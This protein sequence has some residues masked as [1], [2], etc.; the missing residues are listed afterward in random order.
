[1]KVNV[2]SFGAKMVVKCPIR[3]LT[4][5]GPISRLCPQL[6]THALEQ[7]ERIRNAKGSKSKKTEKKERERTRKKFETDNGKKKNFG[8]AHA[9]N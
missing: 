8:L 6:T 3:P 7:P 2:I 9:P 4:D 5:Q 1:M